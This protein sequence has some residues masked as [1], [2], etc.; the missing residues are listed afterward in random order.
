M[1]TPTGTKRSGT[2]TSRRSQMMEMET[3]QRN[4]INQ[5]FMLSLSH[6]SLGTFKGK[7]LWNSPMKDSS[8]I[9]LAWNYPL[10]GSL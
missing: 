5:I 8:F 9:Q 7:N 10:L 4:R 3:P 6:L 1:T 2:D